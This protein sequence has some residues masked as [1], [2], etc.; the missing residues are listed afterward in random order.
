MKELPQN[1]KKLIIRVLCIHQGIRRQEHKSQ[2][3][4]TRIH[5]ELNRLRKEESL[6]V[7]VSTQKLTGCENR[8]DF[9]AGTS[10]N[11]FLC[12]VSLVDCRSLIS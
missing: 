5:A 6:L 3:A 2:T 11:L 4:R 1:E 8:I 7:L 12:L 9:P 10:R